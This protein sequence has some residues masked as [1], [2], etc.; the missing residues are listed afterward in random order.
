MPAFT[1]RIRMPLFPH[2]TTSLSLFLPPAH[3]SVAITT[4]TKPRMTYVTLGAMEIT[5]GFLLLAS[6][7][8]ILTRRARWGE[9]RRTRRQKELYFHGF[10]KNGLRRRLL[11]LAIDS[12]L[13]RRA[14]C[15]Y[16]SLPFLCSA[17]PTCPTILFLEIAKPTFSFVF[18][19]CLLF[20]LYLILELCAAALIK[21]T[22]P[23]SCYIFPVR[24]NLSVCLYLCRPFFMSLAFSP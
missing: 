19:L 9:G 24:T 3:F 13:G 17:H 12:D 8:R 21:R 1:S 15:W 16:I 18:A 10:G 7:S 2:L 22:I 6:F 11:L 20:P 14:C 23:I 5:R 4:T